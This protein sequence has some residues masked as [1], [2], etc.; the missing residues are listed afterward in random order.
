MAQRRSGRT[1]RMLQEAVDRAHAGF[2]VYV[3]GATFKHAE[4]MFRQLI[5]M[6]NEGLHYKAPTLTVQFADGWVSFRTENNNFN[7]DTF[8][9]Y[10]EKGF[11]LVDHYTIESKFQNVM[12]MLHRWE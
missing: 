9:F 3:V 10:G 6:T 4:L 7:W 5:E 8:T 11:V 1:A 12:A 2:N